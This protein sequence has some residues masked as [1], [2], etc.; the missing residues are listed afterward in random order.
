MHLTPTKTRKIRED[1]DT[2]RR[3]LLVRYLGARDR[4]D[5]EQADHSPDL[6][7][8]ANDL[9]DVGIV[10]RMSHNEALALGRIIAALRRLERGTYGVCVDCNCAI[11]L[12]RLS[13]LPEADRCADCAT[14][15]ERA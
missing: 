2:R 11:T 9:W 10:D 12:G 6:I 4:A 15:L 1:L 3:E 5:E 13:A 14:D 8:T 7:D